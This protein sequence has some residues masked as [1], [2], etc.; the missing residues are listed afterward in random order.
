MAITAAVCNSFKADLSALTPHAPTDIFKI[1]LYLSTASLD[2]TTTAYSSTNEVTGAG[3]TAGGQALSGFSPGSSGGVAW[4][5][6][7]TDPAWTGATLSGVRG[8]L[9]YNSS[10]SNK[11][12][13]VI[14]FGSNYSDT[15]G[16]FTVQLPLP[17]PTTAIIRIP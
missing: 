6:W 2:A 17:G 16:T 5:D 9:I 4:I 1:A 7:T 10:K 15:G 3:Y 8:A 11:A 13:A 12:V 14:D